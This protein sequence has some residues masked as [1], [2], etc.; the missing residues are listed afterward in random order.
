MKIVL[1]NDSYCQIVYEQDEIE[2]FGELYN[3]FRIRNP[4][5]KFTPKVRAGLDDGKRPFVKRNGTFAFGIIDRVRKYF[6]DRHISFEDCV[7]NYKEKVSDEYVKS[8]ISKLDLPFKPYKHQYD[9][10]KLALEE[11]R[12]VLLSAT[13]S[14]KSILIYMLARYAITKNKRFI[15][16]VPD[17]GLAQQMRSDFREYFYSNELKIKE[18]LDSEID[19]EKIKKLEN[20]LNLIYEN[21]KDFKCENL[22]DTMHMIVGG[23]DKFKD[24]P[25]IIS[26]WQSIYQ[27]EQDYFD[28]FD[29]LVIDECLSGDTLITMY[30]RTHKQIKDVEIGDMVKTI[31]E[32]TGEIENKKV[33]KKHTNIPSSE[34]FEIETDEGI[35]KIT[36]NHKVMTKRGWVRADELTL[37]D[38]IKFLN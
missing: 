37:D 38:E 9:G 12:A 36:G 13:G 23:E 31:N 27:L 24:V 22:E 6:N 15:L 14:G 29:I 26:T 7:P 16:I 11:K 1:K 35:L 10:F 33:L 25:I 5:L 34:M 17:V 19:K 8:F 32:K 21:R 4:A 18:D 30:D 20:E 3:F 28:G 2:E